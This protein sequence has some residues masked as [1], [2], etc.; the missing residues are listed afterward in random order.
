MFV[1]IDKR[2]LSLKNGRKRSFLMKPKHQCH[3]S[4]WVEWVY[5]TQSWKEKGLLCASIFVLFEKW[6]LV[7]KNGGK[8][9]F[10]NK[11]KVSMSFIPIRIM[12]LWCSIL[13]RKI[14]M[15]IYVYCHWQMNFNSKQIDGWKS[16][17]CETNASMSFIPIKK[18]CL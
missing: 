18:M 13:K 9:F 7:L 5:G 4:Q 2:T 12:T 3:L 16:F 1:L 6:T 15:W 11:T 8:K 10:L 14:T 17:S